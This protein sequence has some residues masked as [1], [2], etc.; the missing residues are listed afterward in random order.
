[1][2]DTNRTLTAPAPTEPDK[3]APPDKPHGDPMRGPPP[4]PWHEPAEPSKKVNLPPDGPAPTI[5][6]PP[7]R[8]PL[9]S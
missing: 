3:Q 4:A 6:V 1:M 7:A 8:E 2:S 5:I 9:V